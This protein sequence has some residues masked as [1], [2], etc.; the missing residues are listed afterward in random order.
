MKIV[1]RDRLGYVELDVDGNGIDFMDGIAYV[2]NDTGDY[3]I[4]AERIIKIYCG[5]ENK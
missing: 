3:R 5:G 1:Y 2:S 4:N